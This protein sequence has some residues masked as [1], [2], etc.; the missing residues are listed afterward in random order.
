MQVCTQS[1]TKKAFLTTQGYPSLNFDN[2]HGKIDIAW[3]DGDHSCV[4]YE[5][6]RDNC[7]CPSCF[8]GPATQSLT[9]LPEVLTEAGEGIRD[10]IVEGD[11]VA[12]Y[13]N[14]G[15][16]SKFK[17]VWLK[18]RVYTDKKLGD[19]PFDIVLWGSEHKDNL[20]LFEFE[21]VVTDDAHLLKWMK[22]LAT[23]GINVLK[24][25][26]RAPGQLKILAKRG[27]GSLYNT[28]YG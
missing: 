25:A 15:H 28:M 19:S 5:F 6:L 18:E 17:S 24:H 27:F 9:L 11:E 12:I 21:K 13:W 26:P 4:P 16:V 1:R 3:G 10:A 8:Y 23:E 20:K 7:Q 2:I 22:V 14:C